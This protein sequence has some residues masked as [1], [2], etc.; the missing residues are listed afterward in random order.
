MRGSSS[1]NANLRRM[2]VSI[3]AIDRSA[4]FIVPIRNRFSGRMNSLSGEYCRLIDW[5]R[6]SSRKYSSPNTLAR[7]ARLI[8]SMIKMYAVLGFAAATSAKSRNGPARSVKVSVPLPPGSGRKPSKKSSYVYEG[9][10]W[11]SLTAPSSVR[12]RASLLARYVFPVPG[13]P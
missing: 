13:G 8:S 1:T 10:N 4:V 2:A 3:R 12:C 7:F 9:W 5:S 6:Y 11:T